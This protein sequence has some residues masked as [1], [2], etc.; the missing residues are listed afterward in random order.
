MGID[1]SKVQAASFLPGLQN[2]GT[3]TA[4]ALV[5]GT[6]PG[7]GTS[8][9]LGYLI[10]NFVIPFPESD[11]LSDIRVTLPNAS[12]QLASRWFPV[13]GSIEL[14]DYTIGFT[15]ILDVLSNSSGR[16]INFNFVNSN[17][18]SYT[19]TNFPIDISA[20][21]YTYPF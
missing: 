17:A 21:L 6:M 5:S 10:G 4:T 16:Q 13:M 19:F 9:N 18:S 11:I 8:P 12:G 14:V 2:I 20:Q 1:L 7:S 15:L 3:A